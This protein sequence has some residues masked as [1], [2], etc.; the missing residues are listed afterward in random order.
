MLPENSNP[1]RCIALVDCNNF[2]ASCERVFNPSW[3]KR[4]LGVLSN[5]DG[6]IIARSNELKD[7]GIPM[8]AP[9]F[10]FKERL[11]EI[12][13]IVVSSNYTL[14]GDMSRR[15]M[16]TLGEFAPKLEVYS[17][18]EAWLDL[19]G[20]ND[21][22]LAGYARRMVDTTQ[23]HTGIPVSIGIAP[24]KSL[25]KI[26]NR[27][28]KSRK[29]AGSVF[30]IRR[31]D[32]L[33]SVLDTFPV[34]EVWGVG[35]KWAEKLTT[36]GI[37]TAWDLRNSDPLY[38]RSVYSVVMQRIIMELRGVNCLEFEDL[39]PRKQIFASRSFGERVTDKESLIEAV[40]MHTLRAAEKLRAQNSSA[41]VLQV[42]I[43][44][45]KHTPGDKYYCRSAT[46]NFPVATSD[47]GKLIG[48]ARAGIEKIYKQGPRY[49]KA[50]I[51]LMEIVQDD[52]AQKGLFDD[53]DSERKKNLMRTLDKINAING[54]HSIF[55]G[56]HST[57]VKDWTMKKNFK[58][59]A[60]TTRWSE[61]PVVK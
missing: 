50:G 44:T 12:G 59:K 22:N 52:K 15:V 51:V 17:I 31:A 21:C 4:P 34:G 53:G 1:S 56:C 3:R 38:M 29:V 23:Q 54:R 14:Y 60:F 40:T 20:M 43:R 19:T 30:H 6:C 39:D 57:K 61:L 47:T 32:D 27:I 37:H 8:G 48:A 18:D 45:G 7:A 35:R 33:E 2:Y 26:A 9:Y 25:A 58:T 46:I 5:N 16:H 10:K 49:A 28:C 42:D 41:K 13:A 36:Q 55:M 11:E 24:T